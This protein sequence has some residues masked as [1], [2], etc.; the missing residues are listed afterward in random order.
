MANI[1]AGNCRIAPLDVI[2][3]PILPQNPNHA[4]ISGFPAAKED[5]M[6]LAIRLAASIEGQWQSPPQSD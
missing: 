2:P 1:R 5:Q 4:N 3:D 6:A